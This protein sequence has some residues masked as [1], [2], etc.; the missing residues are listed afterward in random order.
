MSRA[1]LFASMLGALTMV[2]A[3]CGLELPEG[4]APDAEQL[5]DDAVDSQDTIAIATAITAVPALVMNGESL[6]LAEVVERQ[7]QIAMFV[8]KAE[9]I[10]IE[11]EGNTVRYVLD[12]CT[13]PWGLVKVSGTETVTFSPGPTANSFQ[14]DLASEGLEINGKAAQHNASAVIT[15][16]ADKRTISWSGSYEGEALLGPRKVE[17]E[18]DLDLEVFDDGGYRVDGHSSTKVGIRSLDL[19]VHDLE[20]DGPQGTCPSGVVTAKRDLAALTITLTFDGSNELL[21]ES[22]RGGHDTFD[23]ECEPAGG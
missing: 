13:G 23:L 5:A 19:E 20:R 7:Q 18:L 8:G 6:S 17:H 15:L 4:L 9:C 1:Q 3:S 10:T 12:E 14:V 16:F 21:V 2:G 22:S 11:T